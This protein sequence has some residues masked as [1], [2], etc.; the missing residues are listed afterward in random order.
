MSP[1]CLC[2]ACPVI[3]ETDLYRRRLVFE[4]GFDNP[5]HLVEG[6]LAIAADR[7]VERQAGAPGAA[8][9]LVD[10]LAKNLP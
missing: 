6:A 5:Q 3:V 7:G 10:R 1:G 9:K 2:R 4:P 8:K